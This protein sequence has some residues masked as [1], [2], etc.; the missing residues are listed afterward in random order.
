M[1][2]IFKKTGLA[3]IVLG[4]GF[5]FISDTGSITILIPTF[6]GAIVYALVLL[7]EKF[8]NQ[9]KHF[10]H[11]NLFVLAAGCGATYKSA[12]AIFV[13]YLI[14]GNALSRPLATIEQFTT[15]VLCLAAIIAGIK[16]FRDARKK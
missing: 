9:H 10:A 7:S 14:R 8:P 3:L 5:Y 16:S 1:N 11:A 13:D 6:L 4:V 15:F 2:D 12:I